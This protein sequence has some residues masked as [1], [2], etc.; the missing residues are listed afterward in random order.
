M[1]K[2]ML[3]SLKLK[4]IG[5]K[6]NHGYIFKKINL[7]VDSGKCLTISGQN[8]A[9]KTTL[10]KMMAGLIP[11][12]KGEI[13]LFENERPV[14]ANNIGKIGYLGPYVELYDKLTAKENLLFF[15]SQMDIK[16]TLQEVKGIFIKIGL[17]G[18]EEDLMEGFS[19]GMKQRMKYALLYL[20]KFPVLLLDEPTANFDMAGKQLFKEFI[21]ENKNSILIIASNEEEE[22]KIGDMCIDLS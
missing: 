3:Y 2:N 9:G 15:A 19:S 17:Q 12:D 8:G 22:I 20:K 4:N 7:Q 14:S 13:T 21:K 5:K 6:F 10:L 11:P 1:K 16:I 18:R